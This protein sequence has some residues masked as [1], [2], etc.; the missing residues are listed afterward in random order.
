[1]MEISFQSVCLH[2]SQLSGTPRRVF[3]F[4]WV[5]EVRIINLKSGYF[6]VSCKWTNLAFCDHSQESHKATI[7]KRGNAATPNRAPTHT[8]I[9]KFI[10]FQFPCTTW[11]QQTMSQQKNTFWFRREL[12]DVRKRKSYRQKCTFF[13]FFGA[14]LFWAAPRGK[15]RWDP[16]EEKRIFEG[17]SLFHFSLPARLTKC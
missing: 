12:R 17:K 4:R 5:Y 3:C 8:Q 11:H 10:S 14:T 6:W 13:C 9:W 7:E 2:I 16:W 1:M 15:T